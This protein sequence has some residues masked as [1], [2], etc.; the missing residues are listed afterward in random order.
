VAGEEFAAPVAER[1]EAVA[2]PVPA[3]DKRVRLLHYPVVFIYG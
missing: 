2:V 3:I 1:E